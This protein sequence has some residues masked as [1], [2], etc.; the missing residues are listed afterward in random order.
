MLSKKSLTPIECYE[1]AIS[2]LTEAQD[3]FLKKTKEVNDLITE[4]KILEKEFQTKF[5]EIDEIKAKLKS[6]DEKVF[7]DSSNYSNQN[8][9]EGQKPSN[10]F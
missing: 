2:L 6:E 10:F 4:L 7:T 8:K 1:N 3:I 9:D 5:K